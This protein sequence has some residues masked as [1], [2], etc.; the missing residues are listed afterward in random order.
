MRATTEQL[1]QVTNLL[2]IVSAPPLGTTTIKHVEVL[3]L[4]PQVAMVVVITSTGGVTKRVISYERPVDPGLVDWAGSYL[5]EVLG[6]M[7]VGA[8]MLHAKLRAPELSD[9]RARVPGHARARLHRARRD[10]PRTTS[11]SAAPRGCMSEDRLQELSQIN[12]LMKVLERRVVLLAMLRSALEEPSV[13]LRIGAENEAPELRSLTRGGG[14]LRHRA[15]QPRH[16]QRGRPDPDGLPDRDRLGA[17]GGGRAVALRRR[18]VRRMKRDYY[19]VL[20][21]SRGADEREIKKAFRALARELHPDVNQHDPDAEEKFK[22]VA[23][24]YE[25]LSDPERRAVYDRYGHEGSSRAASRRSFSGFGSFGDIFDA[26][27]GGDSPF[28][29]GDAQRGRSRAATW[30]SRSRSR[31]RRP[32]AAPSVEVDYDAVEACEHCRGNGAEPGTP[33][34]TCTRCGGAGQL[35][36]VQRTAFG[37]LVRQAVCDACG[38]DGKIAK[39]PCR[40]AAAAG[41]RRRSASSTVDIPAGIAD[42]QRIRLTRP[43]PRRRARRARRRPVRARARGGGRA[44]RARRQRPAHRASTC[45]RPTPRSARR[46]RS[47]TLDGT[48]RSRSSPAPSRARS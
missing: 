2:A 27:F 17:A 48:R 25:V 12:D 10:A 5:N 13:Y 29:G 38:G 30:R 7:A 16:G 19:E 39:E 26:F 43:R 24:A 47:P 40:S 34:E 1:S 15:A 42:E 23:E 20:G 4:Q 33:I 46:V 32:R 18:A 35:R 36:A 28:G 11:T 21:V 14:E 9:A 41:A 45:R 37:Q 8:R 3:L 6:G 22:E 31:S 44:L